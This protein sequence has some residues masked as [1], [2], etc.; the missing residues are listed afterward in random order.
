MGLEPKS[1]ATY[2]ADVFSVE[3]FAETVAAMTEL[4]S[5]KSTTHPFDVI[6]FRGVSGAALA[7]PL[8]LS[9]KKPLICVRKD[10]SHAFRE[11]EGWIGYSR[12]IIVDDFKAGGGTINTIITE[13]EKIHQSLTYGV[14]KCVGI[15]LYT[16]KCGGEHNGIPIWSPITPPKAPAKAPAR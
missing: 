14:P 8:S 11:C 2:L 7:F 15:F 16:G 6:A 5:E 1:N 4:I 9:L 10:S 12:Y 13:V 3:K